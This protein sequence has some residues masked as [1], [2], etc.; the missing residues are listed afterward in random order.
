MHK[1]PI[2]ELAPNEV[3]A[4]VESPKGI[5]IQTQNRLRT[6][7]V[8][9]HLLNFA[10]FRCRLA[11][12]NPSVQ[13]TDQVSNLSNYLRVVCEWSVCVSVFGGP[14]YLLLTPHREIALPV[15]IVL[16]FSTLAVILYLRN[17]PQMPFTVQK[18]LWILLL[19]PVLAMLSR[20]T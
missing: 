5:T 8:S 17:S 6:L 15:G 11:S 14:L 9:K 3:T 19:L 7:F 12:W 4:I 2:L 10:E 20:L 13:I 16:F 18:R 1:Y